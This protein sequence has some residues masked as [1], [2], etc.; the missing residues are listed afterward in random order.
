M[1]KAAKAPKTKAKAAKAKAKAA[2]AALPASARPSRANSV[3]VSTDRAEQKNW[4]LQTEVNR[5]LKKWYPTISDQ[6]KYS[7]V[8]E[9]KSLFAYVSAAKVANALAGTYFEEEFWPATA[10]LYDIDMSVRPCAVL[11][12]EE[13]VDVNLVSAMTACGTKQM[14]SRTKSALIA[15][16]KQGRDMNQ[17][18]LCGLTAE[19]CKMTPSANAES[20]AVF[21]E[22]M[23]LIKLFDL[24][25]RFPEEGI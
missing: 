11:N 8:V 7:H 20:A 3:I 4:K 6:Q 17:R 24:K 25:K 2:A 23:K 5:L 13:K 9:S 16:F 1:A 10:R 12:A 15:H 14:K 18:S 21:I 22:F 19:L